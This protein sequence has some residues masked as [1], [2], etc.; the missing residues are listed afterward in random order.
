MLNIEL[1][2][3]AFGYQLF[4][5]HERKRTRG[6]AFT[7]HCVRHSFELCVLGLILARVDLGSTVLQSMVVLLPVFSSA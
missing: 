4:E 5:L 6:T 3:S 2:V 7:M 1:V